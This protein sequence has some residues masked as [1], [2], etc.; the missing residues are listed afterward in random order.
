[1]MGMQGTM[2]R[3]CV[4]TVAALTVTGLLTACGGSGQHRQSAV[5]PSTSRASTR[6]SDERAPSALEVAKAHGCLKK[7]GFRASRI[8]GQI[9]HDGTGLMRYGYLVTRGEYASAVH[10]CIARGSTASMPSSAAKK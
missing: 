6:E 1:M 4:S 9:Q 8:R 7:E 10:R 3:T 2:F 5:I